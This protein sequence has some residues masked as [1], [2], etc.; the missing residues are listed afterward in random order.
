V[1]TRKRKCTSSLTSQGTGGGGEVS[2]RRKLLSGA[3]FDDDKE[4]RMKLAQLAL[5]VFSNSVVSF[6]ITVIMNN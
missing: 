1:N 3:A 5:A 6:K 2:K 4:R